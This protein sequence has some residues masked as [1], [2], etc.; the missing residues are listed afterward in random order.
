MIELNLMLA[1]KISVK[2]G[3]L[4]TP[5]KGWNIKFYTEYGRT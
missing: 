1:K 5:N 4:L 2:I 3:K